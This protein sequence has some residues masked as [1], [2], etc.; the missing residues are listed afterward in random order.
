MHTFEKI[1]YLII[2]LIALYWIVE[3]LG[4][5]FKVNKW[6]NNCLRSQRM[7]HA[8]FEFLGLKVA[9]FPC[10]SESACINW[11]IFFAF[12]SHAIYIGAMW[13]IVKGIIM[14]FG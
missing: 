1:A 14:Y 9:S 11:A 10:T 2:G 8:N 7:T 5:W 12:V 3:I 4:D 13:G 6:L